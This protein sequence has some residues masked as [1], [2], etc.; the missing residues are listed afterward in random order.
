MSE[1][2]ACGGGG[3]GCSPNISAYD[4]KRCERNIPQHFIYGG[5]D[6]RLPDSSVRVDGKVL[7]DH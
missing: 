4:Y 6:S 2:R 7:P 5:D 3:G 1:L